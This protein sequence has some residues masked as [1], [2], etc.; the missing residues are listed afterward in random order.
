MTS[1]HYLSLS[2]SLVNLYLSKLVF[3]FWYT[4]WYHYLILDIIYLFC[5]YHQIL[6][7]SSWYD[8][9]F[10]YNILVITYNMLSILQLFVFFLK[11]NKTQHLQNVFF[12]SYKIWF[13][14]FILHLKQKYIKSLVF[15][16]DNI[17]LLY[18]YIN[19]Y[20]NF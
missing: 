5:Y 20:Y 3:I 15:Q 19:L 2:L 16:L 11:T 1:I 14:Y 4:M 8:T 18:F 6:F 13:S 7:I 17:Y 10:Y 12:T 9:F